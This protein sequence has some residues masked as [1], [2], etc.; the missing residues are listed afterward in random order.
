MRTKYSSRFRSEWLVHTKLTKADFRRLRSKFSKKEIA[1]TTLSAPRRRYILH[2]RRT[3]LP[4]T[5]ELIALPLST[6][7]PSHRP[8]PPD[9]KRSDNA[10]T[11]RNP[12]HAVR[13]LLSREN[14]RMHQPKNTRTR[15]QHEH[16]ATTDMFLA[17]PPHS[18]TRKTKKKTTHLLNLPP[19][20]PAP[21]APIDDKLVREAQPVVDRNQLVLRLTL[22]K[23]RQPPRTPSSP[24]PPVASPTSITPTRHSPDPGVRAWAPSRA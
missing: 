12:P 2:S 15:T 17:H 7:A 22:L 9:V 3:R 18:A 23:P 10:I 6:T 16:F 4:V 21:V 5:L 20:E 11:A 8:L 19:I 13:L 1:R 24:P 14:A